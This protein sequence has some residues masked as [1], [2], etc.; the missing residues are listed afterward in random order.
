MTQHHDPRLVT[1][2][3]A[4]ERTGPPLLALR[5]LRWLRNERPDWH[6]DTVFLDGGGDLVPDFEALGQVI[7]APPVNR[8][9]SSWRP[10]H[11]ASRALAKQLRSLGPIDLV[12]VHCAGSMRV[13]PTLPDAPVLCHVHELSVGLDFHLDLGARRYLPSAQRYVAVSDA[14]R[15]ELLHRFP[16]DPSLV[17]R[18]WGFV[19]IAAL[20]VVPRRELPD[21]TVVADDEMLV[22]A[23]G[24]RHWRKAP[25]LFLRVGARCRELHAEQAWRFV[26]IGGDHDEGLERL[27]AAAGLDDMVTWIDHVDDPLPSIAGAD[28]FML[29]AREDAFPLVSVEAA[30]L[31]RPLLSFDSGGTPEL[32]DAAACGRVVPFPEIDAMVADLADLAATPATRA[33]LGAAGAAFAREHLTIATAGPRLLATIESTMT[34]RTTR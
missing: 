16:I 15:A 27:T 11:A 28:V 24:V 10:A 2:L 12:H 32:I 30:A 34:H 23:S 29:P 21:G 8:T 14:V 3:H 6:L 26:W 17:E 20:D 13:V 31:G 7:V 9:T 22:V 25:E 1:V 18:Q 4:A 19:E 5:F 33:T